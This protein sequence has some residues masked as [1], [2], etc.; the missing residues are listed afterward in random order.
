M[1][2]C[3]ERALGEHGAAG[4]AGEGDEEGVGRHAGA[5]GA[6]DHEVA[7]E[8]QDAGQQVMPLTAASARRRLFGEARRL[9]GAQKMRRAHHSRPPVSR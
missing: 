6:R 3:A 1:K 9:G 4:W 8:A 5:E 7:D 2:A